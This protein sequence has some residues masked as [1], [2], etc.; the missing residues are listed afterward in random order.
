[1]SCTQFYS[2]LLCLHVILISGVLLY[3]LSYYC[4]YVISLCYGGLHDFRSLHYGSYSIVV[5]EFVCA[6]R[7][8]TICHF[9]CLYVL[10]PSSDVFRI[11][12]Q[13]P[14]HSYPQLFCGKVR[15]SFMLFVFICIWWCHTRIYY[16]S[17]MTGV[18]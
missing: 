5:F 14:V 13:F 17:N 12:K 18:L 2:C 16:V 6:Y 8:P 3:I 1:M 11:K 9:I 15:V 4:L 10:F 7:W